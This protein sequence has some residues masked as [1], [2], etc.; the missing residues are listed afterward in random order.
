MFGKVRL[1][2]KS[3]SECIGATR[4]HC[5]LSE[6]LCSLVMHMACFT[7]SPQAGC[8][9]TGQAPLFS[10]MHSGYEVARPALCCWRGLLSESLIYAPFPPY[11]VR[12]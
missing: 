3:C 7:P 6:L 9:P 1:D 4:M 12:V 2:C 5:V 8:T 10:S 11:V